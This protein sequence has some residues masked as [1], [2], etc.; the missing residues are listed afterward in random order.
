MNTVME[1]LRMDESSPA[2]PLLKG[3]LPG[4]RA[5]AIINR[6]NKVLSP[7]YTRGYPLVMDRGQGATVIDVDGAIGSGAGGQIPAH[8]GNRLLLREHGAAG[9]E[10]GVACAG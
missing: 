4:P 10:A 1:E 9:R 6:D 3:P 2:L 8:V 7:S 5:Q